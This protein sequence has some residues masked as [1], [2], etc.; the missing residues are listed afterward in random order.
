MARLGT[1]D[2]WFGV[3]NNSVQASVQSA[4]VKATAISF[5]SCIL[6]ALGWG[7]LGLLPVEAQTGWSRGLQPGEHY[8]YRPE[9]L[10]PQPEVAMAPEEGRFYIDRFGRHFKV[11]RARPFSPGA[12]RTDPAWAP[13]GE[14][15]PVLPPAGDPMEALRP[16]T[17]GGEIEK[18][19]RFVP[20]D[21]GRY[22]TSQPVP[23][24]MPD[25]SQYPK[26]SQDRDWRSE[27]MLRREPVLTPVPRQDWPGQASSSPQAER[28]N[29]TAPAE[30]PPD[31]WQRP[32]GP[33]VESKTATQ[34]GT[35]TVPRMDEPVAKAPEKKP[36][37][38][39]EPE[40]PYA[41]LSYGK[42][43][44]GKKG[45][46]TLEA[47]PNLP[48]IDVRGIAP[49]TPVEFPDP[50]EPTEIIQFRVPKFE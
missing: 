47:H 43:V 33:R 12:V 27:P 17:P 19:R 25:L 37:P 15:V 28:G 32:A 22:A 8:G 40:D 18:A 48:E 29:V 5:S 46:V 44:P 16:G 14:A 42:P 49:G 26:P 23:E 38:P 41:N 36:A 20:G 31:P 11:Y 6:T 34:P 13:P 24:P 39:A 1:T 9:V 35:G 21:S 10:A 30:L 50:R 4:P 2:Y 7:G 45:F 3:L